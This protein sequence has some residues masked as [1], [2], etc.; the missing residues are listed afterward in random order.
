MLDQLRTCT[1]VGGVEVTFTEPSG[2]VY[3]PITGNFPLEE[4]R[5]DL[6]YA[7]ELT[8]TANPA[9]LP[10]G[11]IQPPNPLRV[12]I[13]EEASD[14]LTVYIVLLPDPNVSTPVPAAAL[15]TASGPPLVS[16]T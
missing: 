10:G 12:T 14:Y 2:F 1:E 13:P 3:G 8:I 4:S 16:G 7:K 5:L 9:T 6:P 15:D 11:W